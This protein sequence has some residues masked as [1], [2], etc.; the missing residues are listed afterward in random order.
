MTKV[1][2]KKRLGYFWLSSILIVN[3]IPVAPAMAVQKNVTIGFQG[4]LSG[5]ESILGLG[6][7]DAVKFAVHHFNQQ[8]ADTFKVNVI[9]IDDQGDP[10]IAQKIAP[11][12]ASNTNILGL[13]GPSY[14]GATIAS[15]PFY[16][17]QNLPIISPSATRISL[18]D[19]LQG[20]VGFPIFHR[21]T[22]IE[23]MQGTAL[24]NLATQGVMTP[25]VLIV[26]DFSSYAVGLS[27]N[28]RNSVRA[29]T[30]VG[31]DSLVQSK[32][33]SSWGTDWASALNRVKSLNVNVVIYTGYFSQAGAF[34]TF[35]RSNG[36][37]GILAGGDGVFSN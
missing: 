21:V 33:A 26:D 13:V 3:V 25:R 9:E 6:Q 14:S 4:P 18:T 10:S 22:S 1:D 29:Q 30:I 15:L 5:P 32:G 17:P 36:Y 12:I 20:R 11:A 24:Y 7:L 2:L 8:F 37:T 19:P 34:F 31:T 27:N 23:K 28:I 35:L 16:I